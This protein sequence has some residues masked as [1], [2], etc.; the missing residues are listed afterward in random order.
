M[1]VYACVSCEGVVVGVDDVVEVLGCAMYVVLGGCV[2]VSFV[3][4]VG[5]EGVY[6]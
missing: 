5:K 1:A 3:V 2:R 6:H 4:G